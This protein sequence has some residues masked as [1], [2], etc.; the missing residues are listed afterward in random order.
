VN[1]RG[2]RR[3]SQ[4]IS[5]GDGISVLVEVADPDAARAAERDGA[6]GVVVRANVSGLRDATELPV[7][8]C[9][10]GPDAAD[11]A[12]A[13]ACVLVAERYDDDW[14][15]LADDHAR[16]LELGLDCVVEVRDEEELE[17]TFEHV[18]PE[19]VL[20]AGE[21]DDRDADPLDHVLELL[22]DVPAG[23]LAVAHVVVTSRDEVTALERAGIDAVIVR[24][25]D[26]SAL[27]GGQPPT[28]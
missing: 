9:A 20:L 16:V 24:A 22:P 1:E 19:I 28:F 10:G 15:R 13:D 5:E 6:D 7:L 21:S 11:A 12:G 25:N 26:V 3:F 2:T 23:K 17:D 4:A 14:S 27:V 18:D 8:W